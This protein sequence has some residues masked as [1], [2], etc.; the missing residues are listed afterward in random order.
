[1]YLLIVREYGDASL[2]VAAAKARMNVVCVRTS[3]A[4]NPGAI[5][6]KQNVADLRVKSIGCNYYHDCTRCY[7]DGC[8]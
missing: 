1:M 4:F 5:N 6:E 7:Q 3:V 2:I 8:S